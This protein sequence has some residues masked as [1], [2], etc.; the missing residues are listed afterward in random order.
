MESL[1]EIGK[2]DDDVPSD[3]DGGGEMVVAGKKE[4]NDVDCDERAGVK[5]KTREVLQMHVQFAP[6]KEMVSPFI[7]APPTPRRLKHFFLFMEVVQVLF[8]ENML[9]ALN[10]SMTHLKPIWWFVVGMNNSVF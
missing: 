7:I 1:L 10:Q 5:A 9:A 2:D 6:Q 8:L 4:R 3:D